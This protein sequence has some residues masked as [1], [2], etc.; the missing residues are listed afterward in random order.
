MKK[1]KFQFIESGRPRMYLILNMFDNIRVVHDIK[2]N[3]NKQRCVGPPK[4]NQG[5]GRRGGETEEQRQRAWVERREEGKG[6]GSRRRHAE[7]N[8]R[9]QG[10]PPDREEEGCAVYVHSHY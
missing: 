6:S 2:N 5:T 1:M 4:D 7:A 8:L 3:T 10:L 9:D